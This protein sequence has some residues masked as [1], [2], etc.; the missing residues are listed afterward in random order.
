[1][2][3]VEDLRI[4]EFR[5]KQSPPTNVLNYKTQE[6]K[7]RMKNT[8]EHLQEKFSFL[9]IGSFPDTISLYHKYC[10]WINYVK[11]KTMEKS[12]ESE[13]GHTITEQKRK[14]VNKEKVKQRHGSYQI[15]RVWFSPPINH[16]ISS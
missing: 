5:T 16:L 11:G 7:I 8:S 14:I 3:R 12:L 15:S 6:Q 2:N 9:Q 1:M 4:S 13:M 10:N